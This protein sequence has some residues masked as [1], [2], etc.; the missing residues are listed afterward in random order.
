MGNHEW[1]FVTVG[2][3]GIPSNADDRTRI[4]KAAMQSFRRKERIERV[5][6]FATEQI[7][8]KEP[9]AQLVALPGNESGSKLSSEASDS[10]KVEARPTSNFS[11]PPHKIEND[12]FVSGRTEWPGISAK[13]G[14]PITQ[15]HEDDALMKYLVD[16]CTYQYTS[17]VC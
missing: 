5:E 15:P 8:K 1:N 6:A 12:I 2:Q 4:R 16:Y 13:L 9:I 11:S 7:Q 3:T 14:H 10:I 17:S